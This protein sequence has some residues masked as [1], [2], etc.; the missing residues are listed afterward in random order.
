MHPYYI[1]RAVGGS[2]F[3]LGAIVACYNIWMTIRA[4]QPASALQDDHPQE[5]TDPVLEAGR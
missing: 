2:L 5:R 1:A 4:P 3:L